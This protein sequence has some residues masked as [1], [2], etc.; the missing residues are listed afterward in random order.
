MRLRELDEA[1]AAIALALHANQVASLDYIAWLLR[2]G[3]EA[4][5][6]E[7][8]ARPL[9][10]VPGDRF[11]HA[12][13]QQ[14]EDAAFFDLADDRRLKATQRALL[15]QLAQ[16]GCFVD[17]GQAAYRA[18]IAMALII[19]DQAFANSAVGRVLQVA[20]DG[21]GD[22]EPFGVGL[23]AVAA[24]HFR[25]DHFRYIG[26]GDFGARCVMAGVA[27]L[28]QGGFIALLVDPAE[29]VHA[30]EDP[31]AALFGSGGVGQRVEA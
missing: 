25:A 19:G 22:V 24:D 15:A 9:H 5:G 18:A 23:A 4:V 20:R 30:S 12:A 3:P 27:R 11:F 28:G 10:A 8:G 1:Q 16:P 17:V 21:G 13:T 6:V 2:A 29:H 26:G 14:H 7:E 31:V